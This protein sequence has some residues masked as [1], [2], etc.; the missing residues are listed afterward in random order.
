MSKSGF[1]TALVALLQVQRSDAHSWVACT[2]YR[3][4]NPGQAPQ[5]P[6]EKDPLRRHY[7]D[8]KCHAYPRD[9]GEFASQ[10]V[11]FGLDLGYN[12]IS[13]PTAMCRT[14]RGDAGDY[15][16]QY[17]MA[18]YQ[19]GQTVCLAYPAKNHAAAP[20]TNAYIPDTE[21]KIYRSLEGVTT[22]PTLDDFEKYNIPH[23]NGVHEVRR[24]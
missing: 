7:D 16:D 6:S 2:D 14:P 3:V 5:G 22:D 20:C 12:Y 21:F 8:T 9:W 13:T 23:K 19:P 24:I 17:P 18:H 1:I 11:A 10:P 4:A 15:S